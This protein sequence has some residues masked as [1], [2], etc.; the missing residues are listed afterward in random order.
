MMKILRTT[1]ALVMLTII[2]SCG[3]MK[4]HEAGENQSPARSEETENG[5]LGLPAEIMESKPDFVLEEHDDGQVRAVFYAFDF[6]METQTI[7]G[8]KRAFYV[9][10]PELVN[11]YF[12]RVIEG[13]MYSVYKLE[14][15]VVAVPQ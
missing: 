12:Q 9:E 11:F 3:T 15:G 8:E 10:S 14:N 5:R 6:N 13:V 4:K 2:V 1:G 7:G